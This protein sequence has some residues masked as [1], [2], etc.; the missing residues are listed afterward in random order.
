MY[1]PPLFCKRKMKLTGW[2]AQ[3]Y[4]AFVGV[5]CAP[6]HDGMRRALFLSKETVSEDCF[7][8]QVSRAPGLTVVPSHGSP[9]DLAGSLKTENLYQPAAAAGLQMWESQSD[10]QAWRSLPGGI[11]RPV[12]SDRGS[13]GRHRWSVYFPLGQHCPGD[14]RQLIGQRDGRH[15][16]VLSRGQPLQPATQTGRLL[17]AHLQDSASTLDEESSQ[18][19]VASF[20]DAEQP[21]LTTG[22]VFTGH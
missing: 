10:F 4:S 14:A 6:G 16:G 18:I 2:S 21:L 9:A 20:A 15:M 13:V 8:P 11:C 7:T 22:G 3:M 12:A 5:S 1:G 19:G 17:V